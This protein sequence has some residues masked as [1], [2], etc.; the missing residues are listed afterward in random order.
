M[1]LEPFLLHSQ[2]CGSLRYIYSQIITLIKEGKLSASI[3]GGQYGVPV[4]TTAAKLQKYY[5]MQKQQGAKELGYGK[6][7]VQ[8]RML[9]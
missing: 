2:Q 3:A 5:Q 1:R 6:Y 7:Q 4:C 9:H 8:P